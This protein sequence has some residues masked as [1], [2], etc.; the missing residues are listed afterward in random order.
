MF[1]KITY[2][3]Y[4]K[5][6]IN[7]REVMASISIKGKRAKKA[8]RNLMGE[9]TKLRMIVTKKCLKVKIW[10]KMISFQSFSLTSIIFSLG[11]HNL[12]A[13]CR[14]GSHQEYLH[15]PWE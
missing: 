6:D 10:M 8:I 11:S 3:L 5:I 7:I 4:H 14:M 2:L 13:I 15:H 12:K 1:T 9:M